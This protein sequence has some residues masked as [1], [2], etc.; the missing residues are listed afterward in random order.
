VRERSSCFVR[1]PALRATVAATIWLVA[2]DASAVTLAA[3]SSGIA[4]LPLDFVENRGQ[5]STP[6]RFVA[7]KDRILTSFENDAI[8]L[9]LAGERPAS[10]ALTF[11]G[12]SRDA[13]LV[14]EGK[15]TTE[16]PADRGTSAKVVLKS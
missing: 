12:A 6:A 13:R 11:E 9:H 5:W 8:R 1:R 2:S 14:G 4:G 3:P 7:R 15:R 16:P 10:V